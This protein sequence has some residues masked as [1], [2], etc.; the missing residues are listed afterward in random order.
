MSFLPSKQTALV[1][2][3]HSEPPIEGSVFF[4]FS[5][6][7]PQAGFSFLTLTQVCN[8]IERNPQV[9]SSEVLLIRFLPILD[10]FCLFTFIFLQYLLNQELKVLNLCLTSLNV[11][12]F[13]EIRKK[14]CIAFVASD[15]WLNSRP[16]EVFRSAHI[17]FKQL[18]F[19]C[20]KST[21]N[22]AGEN[23]LFTSRNKR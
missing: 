11:Q 23:N 5:F 13:V 19:I 16:W 1:P 6:F 18:L 3:P 22:A 20:H 7:L 8:M 2:K 14:K 12:N 17:W 15:Q 4:F 10:T 21:W 9:A